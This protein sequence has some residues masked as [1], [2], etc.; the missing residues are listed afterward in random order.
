MRR[1]VTAILG[2]A[3][4]LLVVPALAAPAWIVDEGASSISFV[5]GWDGAQFEGQFADWGATIEFSPGALANA[6]IDVRIDTASLSSGNGERDRG[7]RGEVW[8]NVMGFPSARFLSTSIAQGSE[9]GFVAV[10]E[11]SIK[12]IRR[13]VVAPFSWSEEGGTNLRGEIVLD[14]RHFNIGEGEWALDP[15]VAFNVTVR[16]DLRLRKPDSLASVDLRALN[17]S[18]PG[19]NIVRPNVLQ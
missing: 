11:L 2:L 19:P 6:V 5:T 17:N 14:R 18:G 10:G 3:W 7:I 1:T 16:H 13:P 12:G 15:L 9:A 8:F 4:T